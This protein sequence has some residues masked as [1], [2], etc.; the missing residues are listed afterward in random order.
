MLTII[1]YEVQLFL[2]T[3][4]DMSKSFISNSKSNYNSNS[5][6]ES[7]IISN[8]KSNYNSNSIQSPSQVM[9]LKTKSCL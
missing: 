9:S 3:M 2:Y 8:S 1:K 5:I 4:N 6:H 7:F